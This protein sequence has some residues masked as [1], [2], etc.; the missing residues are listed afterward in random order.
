MASRQGIPN[1]ALSTHTIP[2]TLAAWE[3]QREGNCVGADPEI[4]FLAENARMGTKVRAEKA[5]KEVCLGCP[6]REQCLTQALTVPEEYG[7]WGGT[8]P[9]E[10]TRIQLRKSVVIRT[11]KEQ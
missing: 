9:E 3:W 11:T 7:V 2:A 5:A 1:N 10:R 6:V 4:F 8:T